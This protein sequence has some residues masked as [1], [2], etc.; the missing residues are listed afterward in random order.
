[1]LLISVFWFG[2]KRGGGR[3]RSRQEGPAR[4]AKRPHGWRNGARDPR[5]GGIRAA[6][7]ITLLLSACPRLRLWPQARSFRRLSNNIVPRG[8]DRDGA[9][10]VAILDDFHE[11]A[12]L[13]G[14]E[15]I[16][17]PIVEDEEI[18]LDQHAEQA[19]EAAVA[20]GDIESGEQA[21]NPGVVDG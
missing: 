13:A 21:R 14:G 2:V 3:P 20:V 7:V 4:V 1:V 16:R 19:R 6:R 11:I 8:G 9:A 15:A 10:A 12:V 18:D 17:S 5:G